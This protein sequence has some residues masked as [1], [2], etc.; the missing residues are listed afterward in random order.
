[1]SE[2]QRANILEAT[3]NF[4]LLFFTQNCPSQLFLKG[5]EK[6]AVVTMW[7]F[8]SVIFWLGDLNYRINDLDL[9]NVKDLISKKDL[10]T[11]YDYDQVMD[12]LDVLLF[13]CCPDCSV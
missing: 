12:V 11:L 13:H 10:K 2:E 4:A 6:G 1:M 7:V 8:C 5:K 9:E 3:A